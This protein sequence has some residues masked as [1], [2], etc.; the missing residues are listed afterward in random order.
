LREIKKSCFRALF[1]GLYKKK[2]NNGLVWDPP[3]Y[4]TQKNGKKAKRANTNGPIVNSQALKE[5]DL[6]K[7]S[8]PLGFIKEEA[9]SAN[10]A[11][12][13][14]NKGGLLRGG[15]GSLRSWWGIKE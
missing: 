7:I 5:E 15:V 1:H 14:L 3:D 13:F 6:I 2:K 10:A 8:Q 12:L 4:A 9:R 11:P